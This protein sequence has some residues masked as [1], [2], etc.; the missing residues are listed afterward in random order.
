[1]FSNGHLWKIRYIR[2]DLLCKMVHVKRLNRN[3]NSCT[4]TSYDTNW[5]VKLTVL[6]TSYAKYVFT[7]LWNMSSKHILNFYHLIFGIIPILSLSYTSIENDSDRHLVASFG[8]FGGYWLENKMQTHHPSKS[9][10]LRC[11]DAF[12]EL[13]LSCYER[14]VK[15][16]WLWKP[17]GRGS[18]ISG[19][20]DRGSND[21]RFNV[22][23][24]NLLST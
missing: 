14:L 4:N 13:T 19:S 23:C 12:I 1:M 16:S 7:L 8:S 17:K 18:L 15:E 22:H 2:I 21:V 5:Y 20:T 3:N 9:N 24:C 6:T 11:C 10:E